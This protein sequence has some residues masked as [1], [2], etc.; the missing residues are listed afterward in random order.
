[1]KLS[2]ELDHEENGQWIAEVTSIPGV[3]AY[4]LTRDHAISRVEALT[5]RVIADRLDLGEPIP[6]LGGLFSVII[7]DDDLNQ[8]TSYSS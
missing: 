2:I 5:L 4:G 6:E 7:R 3:M 8:M 1:M